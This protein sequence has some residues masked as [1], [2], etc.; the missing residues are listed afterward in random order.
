MSPTQVERLQAAIAEL[1]V[2]GFVV[3]H[4]PNV[5]WLTSFTGSFGYGLV[6]P[7]QALFLTDSR[8]T[9][10]SQE[11]VKNLECRS[12]RQPTEPHEFLFNNVA[13]LGIKKL[14]IDAS[15][16]PVGMY[17]K[18]QKQ[19]SQGELVPIKDPSDTLRLIKSEEEIQKIAKACELSDACLEMI[20][21]RVRPGETEIEL[22][23]EIEAFMRRHGAVVS[24][25]PIVV[26]G[27]RSARP[28]GEA[29]DKK[30]EAGDFITFDL[31]ARLDGYC[32]DITRTFVVGEATDRH[33]EVYN[34]VLKAQCACI[35][36]L[37][38]GANG[39][40]VDGLARKILDEKDLAKYFGHGLGHGLGGE[41]HDT[42]RLSSTMDQA[43]EKNQVWTVEPGVYIEGFGGVRIE[44]DI[45]VTDDKPIVLNK[46]TKDLL[47]LR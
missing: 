24:F 39:R 34:Q 8:Y 35:E 43:I 2:D 23:I 46:F 1:D 38:P 33:R 42:G 36:A 30:L 12:F 14:G 26:S 47:E 4:M 28:H 18:W 17:E 22:H 29:S 32:S 9:I 7:D 15:T 19:F 40:E 45:V 41:V 20:R 31:G 16:L 25:N 5:R 37:V 6:T 27:N 11:E 3:S 21:E 10:Q 13:E 44:D